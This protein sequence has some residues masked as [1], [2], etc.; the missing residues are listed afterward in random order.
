MPVVILPLTGAE[1]GFLI[2]SGQFTWARRGSPLL[3]LDFPPYVV[4]FDPCT[5]ETHFLNELPALILSVVNRE[6]ATLHCLV[7]RIAGPEVAG[8]LVQRQFSAALDF[9]VA[10]NLVESIDPSVT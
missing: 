7:E 5:G 10:A 1:A 4:C 2:D 6:P 9:L 3:N 8:E